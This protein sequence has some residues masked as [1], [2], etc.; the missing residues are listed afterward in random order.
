ML[1][2]RIV[3]MDGGKA[4]A[5]MA[6]TARLRNR[7]GAIH[8]GAVASL[9]DTVMGAAT[10]SAM[11]PE[12]WCATVSLSI[13]YLAASRSRRVRARASVTRR[14]RCLA[15]VRGEIEDADGTMLAEAQGV[16]YVW[17]GKPGMP[18]QKSSMGQG[19][20]PRSER[21]TP[22]TSGRAIKTGPATRR[23]RPR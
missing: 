15:F 8:G 6:A 11:N 1:G 3:A 19:S 14:A 2:I 13:H 20:A 22:G 12:E 17:P 4:E 7:R 23:P 16:W 9:L 5:E 21:S 10:I 18:P